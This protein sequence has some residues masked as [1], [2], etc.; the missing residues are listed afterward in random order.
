MIKIYTTPAC[1]FCEMAKEFLKDKKIA[2]KEFDISSN[3]KAMKEMLDKT[4]QYGVPVFDIDGKI[5]INFNRVLLE[6]AIE[7]AGKKQKAKEKKSYGV[8][9]NNSRRGTGRSGRR[10]LRRPKKT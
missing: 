2:Y 8:R 3:E 9:T 4:H 5:L 1:V 7:E 10:N 6:E